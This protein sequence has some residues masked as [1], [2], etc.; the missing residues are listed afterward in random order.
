MCAIEAANHMRLQDK[1]C[2]PHASKRLTTNAEVHERNKMV[3]M[4]CAPR[5]MKHDALF[6]QE[7]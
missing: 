5:P 4:S 6:L 7:R 2:G 3:H 1:T